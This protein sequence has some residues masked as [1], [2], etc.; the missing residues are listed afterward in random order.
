ML[1]VVPM[2][3][4]QRGSDLVSLFDRPH[5]LH[6]AVQP[7][8][9]EESRLDDEQLDST[10]TEMIAKAKINKKLAATLCNIF[11]SMDPEEQISS[12]GK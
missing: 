3:S 5:A 7:S 11:R 8:R 2:V 1:Q 10:V 6:S 9:S 4:A 12:N